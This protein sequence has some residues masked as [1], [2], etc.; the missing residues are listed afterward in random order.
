MSTSKFFAKTVL[1]APIKVIFR[2]A[3][4]WVIRVWSV[5]WWRSGGFGRRAASVKLVDKVDGVDGVDKV[6]T[7]R[8]RRPGGRRAGFRHYLLRRPPDH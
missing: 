4:L 8:R 6:E 3:V 7:V 5:W 1:P 2:F